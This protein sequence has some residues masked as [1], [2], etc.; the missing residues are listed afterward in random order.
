MVAIAMRFADDG[1]NR[2]AIFGVLLD[3]GCEAEL[4]A[5]IA[6]SVWALQEESRWAS[7]PAVDA[8]DT[9][10]APTP[11]GSAASSPDEVAQPRYH[12]GAFDSFWYGLFG[13]RS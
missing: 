1:N 2:D 10:A 9:E 12:P 5:R 7:A 4:A 3:R 13:I 6:D 8:P 11:A